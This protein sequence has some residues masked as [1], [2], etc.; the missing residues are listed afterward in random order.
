MSA[1]IS[2]IL[3]LVVASL[4][5]CGG[6]SQPPANAGDEPMDGNATRRGPYAS[7]SFFTVGLRV[8]LGPTEAS[9]VRL[10]AVVVDVDGTESI[11][12][13][14]EYVG[15]LEESAPEGTEIGHLRL[16]DGDEVHHLTLTPTDDP[17]LLELRLD[18]AP[19]RRLQLPQPQ[20]VRAG[21]P[22]LLTAP[23]E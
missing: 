10:E 5:A 17:T 20:P 4:V 16:R 21:Q 12:D 8:A 2:S 11:T 9:R 23:T 18:G 7:G 19:V 15:M 3:V 6:P 14:G 1:R 13:L 22:F